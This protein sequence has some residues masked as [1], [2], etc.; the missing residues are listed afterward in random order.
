M[1]NISSLLRRTVGLVLSI[2][3]LV[4]LAACHFP[5]LNDTSRGTIRIAAQ[6]TTEG[7]ILAEVIKQLIIHDTDY[8]A[9]VISN[10]ESGNMTFAALKRGDA[11]VSAVRYTGTDLE[12]VMD[13]KY[14]RSQSSKQINQ[15]VFNYF[16]QHYKMTY[17]PTYGF[18]DKYVWLVTPQ[19]A[20]AHNLQNVSDLK[21]LAS[22][23]KVGID[24]TWEHRQGDGYQDFKKVYGYSFGKLHTMESGL[25]YTAVHNGSMDAVLGESTAG[26]I[27]AYHL[28]ILQDDQKFFPPYDCSPVVTNQALKKYPRLKPVINKLTGQIRLQEMQRLNYEV[29]NG[30]KE[31]AEVARTFLQQHDYFE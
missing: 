7:E 10:L 19:Y 31:P 30:I 6:S 18:A 3:M 8:Q 12:T 27:S 13:Q 22:Q 5:G 1:Q 21:P 16:Q 25:F 2:L 29:E 24:S 17:F 9:S 20:K 23:M 14:D 28:K 11:D 26:R 15:H 4:T